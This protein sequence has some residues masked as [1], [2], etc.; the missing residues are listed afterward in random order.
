MRPAIFLDRDGVICANRDDY[1]KSWDEFRF[2]PGAKKA[3]RQLAMLGWPIIVITN[4]SA[5]GR[6]LLSHRELAAIHR[7]M[8][9]EIVAA[10]GRLDA[11]FYCPHLPEEHC[12]CRKPNP[13]MLFKAANALQIDL[14]RSILVGDAISDIEAGARAGVPWRYLVLTGRG[15]AAL[16]EAQSALELPYFIVAHDLAEV[17]RRLTR[18]LPA[19]VPHPAVAVGAEAR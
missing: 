6:K 3:I 8:E 2:L 9:A 14:E 5:V 10:G 11:L 7:R 12:P 15:K 17:A 18:H 1:V 13:G 4:Q 19:E 16:R